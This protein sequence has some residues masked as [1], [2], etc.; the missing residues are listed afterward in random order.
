M[1]NFYSRLNFTQL[2]K[3]TQDLKHFKSKDFLFTKKI[4]PRVLSQ[5]LVLRITTLETQ[6]RLRINRWAPA[7]APPTSDPDET[8]LL[9]LAQSNLAKERNLWVGKFLAK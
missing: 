4:H 3:L 8:F 1:V 7:P 5:F 6:A 2:S 9:L